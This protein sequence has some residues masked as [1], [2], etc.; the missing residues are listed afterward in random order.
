MCG[1]G[2]MVGVQ[3]EGTGACSYYCCSYSMDTSFLIAAQGFLLVLNPQTLMLCTPAGVQS[4]F[5]AY[6]GTK[7]HNS[8][9][10]L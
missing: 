7:S 3:M 4:V 2:K 10:K 5:I 1:T 9:N 6:K 8:C